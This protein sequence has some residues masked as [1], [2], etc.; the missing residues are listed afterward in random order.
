MD[1]C[2][3]VMCNL[4]PRFAENPSFFTHHFS[5]TKLDK[6]RVSFQLLASL[7]TA[8]PTTQLNFYILPF[9]HHFVT[10]AT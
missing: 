9:N 3:T 1:E 10:G 8:Y 4:C 6:F 2:L 7:K 5:G